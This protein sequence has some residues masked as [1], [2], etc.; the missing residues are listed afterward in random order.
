MYRASQNDLSK[1]DHLV[2]LVLVALCCLD[3]STCSRTDPDQWCLPSSEVCCY[4]N[5]ISSVSGCFCIVSEVLSA[6]SVILS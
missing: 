6:L 2:W 1:S 5:L 3:C 4:N